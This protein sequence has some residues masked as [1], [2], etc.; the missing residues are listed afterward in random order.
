MAKHIENRTCNGCDH[1]C[2]REWECTEECMEHGPFPT[3]WYIEKVS[4]NGNE[5]IKITWERYYKPWSTEVKHIIIK[6]EK[7]Q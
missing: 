6:V 3:S 2:T 4:Y 5:E 7:L 1:K